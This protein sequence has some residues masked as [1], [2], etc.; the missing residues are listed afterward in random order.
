MGIEVSQKN[1]TQRNYDSG[2]AVSG[3]LSNLIVT[4]S[5]YTRMGNY[6]NFLILFSMITESLLPNDVG[7]ITF[8][9]PISN[10]NF[11]TRNNTSLIVI[12]GLSTYSYEF[13]NA[14][15]L[16]TLDFVFFPVLSATTRVC[17]I[18]SSYYLT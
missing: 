5:K 17:T 18:N 6:V 3:V 8:N 15:L 10:P 11:A 4:Y 7:Q 2:I 13:S 1:F 14:A 12:G 16:N 9:N